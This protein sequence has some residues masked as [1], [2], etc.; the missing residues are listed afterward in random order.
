MWFLLL[1]PVPL[2]NNSTLA[3]TRRP[4]LAEWPN[5]NYLTFNSAKW[6]EKHQQK[7]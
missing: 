4:T 7:Q 2:T 1:K 6:E 3:Y 5:V